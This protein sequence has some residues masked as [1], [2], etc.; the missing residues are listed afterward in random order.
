MG[1]LGDD[2][3][4]HAVDDL[5]RLLGDA[6]RRGHSVQLHVHPQWAGARRE[7]CRW[8]LPGQTDLG[9]L[10]EG[11]RNQVLDD[12][13]LWV[14]QATDRKPTAFRAG[15][16]CASPSAPVFGALVDRGVCLDSTVMP[17][18]W[19]RDPPFDFRSA[20]VADRRWTFSDDPRI[21]GP[22]PLTELAIATAPLSRLSRWTGR[23]DRLR[24]G[25]RA[26]GCTLSAPR[27]RP[28]HGPAALDFC[29]WPVDTLMS[30]VDSAKE[31]GP[32]PIVAI[33][34]TKNFTAAAE[35]ALEA[36]ILLSGLRC[37]KLTDAA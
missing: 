8:V 37:A 11:T 24:T 17:G 31:H 12:A 7:A 9:T 22:G 1:A 28:V 15:A 16:W 18:R 23:L 32:D 26:P 36:M 4:R 19:Q 13:I 33:G 20:P 27:R 3:D 5:L 2:R 6:T 10:P 14:S 35:S 29:A 21:P 30:I 34:H 25:F